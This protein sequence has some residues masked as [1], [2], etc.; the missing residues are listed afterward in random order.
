LWFVL[1]GGIFAR[2]VYYTVGLGG[3]PLTERREKDEDVGSARLAH[4]RARKDAT[5]S[6]SNA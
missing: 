2:P 4:D 6:A 1:A 3:R 5:G